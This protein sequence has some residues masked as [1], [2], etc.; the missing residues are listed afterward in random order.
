MTKLE[1]LLKLARDAKNASCTDDNYYLNKLIDELKINVLKQD[2][3]TKTLK[4]YLKEV[5]HKHPKQYGYYNINNSLW[6]CDSH[7]FIKIYKDNMPSIVF[8]TLKE[9]EENEAKKAMKE[10]LDEYDHSKT[11]DNCIE[12]DVLDI[13]E[14]WDYYKLSNDYKVD[15]K[16]LMM[17]AKINQHTKLNIH[18]DGNRI[19]VLTEAYNFLGVILPIK[20]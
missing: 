15:T 2:S 1:Y 4:A 12:I 5:K 9:I 7:S 11:L 16:K 13:C 17:F 18:L 19:Y 10:L 14:Q 6:V 8:K 3:F 20:A